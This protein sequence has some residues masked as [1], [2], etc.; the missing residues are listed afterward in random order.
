MQLKLDSRVIM[1]TAA[2]FMPFIKNLGLV[3]MVLLGCL[4]VGQEKRESSKAVVVKPTAEAAE[5]P[6][7]QL[8]LQGVKAPADV[9]GLRV[10]LNP[11]DKTSLGTGNA[12]YVGTVYFSHPENNEQ[13]EG[14]FVLTL[15]RKVTAPT[16]VVLTPISGEGTE[17]PSNATLQLE[18]ARIEPV[19]NSKFK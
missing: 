1:V 14:S 18:A 11:K 4:L 7:Q 10:F 16:R 2:V 9:S 17:L 5:A 3:A 8:V 19:D 13:H 6:Q 12:G 15:P